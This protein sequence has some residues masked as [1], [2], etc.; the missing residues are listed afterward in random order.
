MI[1]KQIILLLFLLQASLLVAQYSVD[2]TNISFPKEMDPGDNY[3]MYAT[4][5]NTGG[6]E[7][8]RSNCMLEIEYISGPDKNAGENF[9]YEYDLISGLTTNKEYTFRW[10]LKSPTIPGTYKLNLNI[11]KG[12]TTLASEALTVLIE[13]NFEAEIINNIDGI[14]FEPEK[15]YPPI[16]ITIKNTGETTWP[17][18]SY[19]IEAKVIDEPDEASDDDKEAFEFDKDIYLQ[20]L[21][22]GAYK[23][24]ASDSFETPTAGGTYELQVSI[25]KD[26][27]TFNANNGVIT[28]DCDVEEESFEVDFTENVTTK[29]YPE[30]EYSVSFKVKNSGNIKWPEAD[31]SIKAT[32]TSKASNKVDDKVFEAEVDFNAEEWDPG[33][34]TTVNFP[35]IKTPLESGKYTVKYEILTDR[36]SFEA[37]DSEITVNYQVVELEP[38]LNVNRITLEKKMVSGKSYKLRVDIKNN[39]DI[40]GFKDDWVVKC[41]IRSKKPSN[42]KPPRGV[43]EFSVDGIEIK[44][45]ETKYVS[46]TIKT[47]K[48]EQETNIRLEFEVYYKGSRMGGPKTYDIVIKP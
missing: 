6:Q 11:K 31:F 37:D 33:E 7:L 46:G 42:Y 14:K 16:S 47:P 43:F 1:Q 18:G 36:E 20:N 24:I 27:K 12:T 19:K 5:K 45:K 48:V 34:Y 17:D 38:E 13:E 44:S 15:E 35:D 4:I 3:Q 21:A 9:E 28:I 8:N 26:G 10:S 30:K 41:K 32:L 22:P 25:L 29:I 40:I 39:G 2:I 23:S